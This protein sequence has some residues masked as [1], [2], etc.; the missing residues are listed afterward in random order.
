MV[1]L[2]GSIS[3]FPVTNPIA[4]NST[5]IIQKLIGS[6]KILIRFFFM[7]DHGSLCLIDTY[8]YAISTCKTKHR[9]K[10][11]IK[12]SNI[13]HQRDT[14]IIGNVTYNPL[15]SFLQKRWRSSINNMATPLVIF[16]S[17][18]VNSIFGLPLCQYCYPVIK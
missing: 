13:I 17:C 12:Q 3:A 15:T 7:M 10:C 9:H 14:I 5:N 16:I 6:L 4:T 2:P 1:G 8:K 11:I 18:F